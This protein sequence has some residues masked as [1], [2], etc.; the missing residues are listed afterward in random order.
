MLTL[1]C[2]C[3]FELCFIKQKKSANT[4][5]T[6]ISGH[7]STTAQ[8]LQFHTELKKMAVIAKEKYFLSPNKAK[9]GKKR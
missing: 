7:T 2:T 9:S 4:A 8:P 1:G 6:Q 3:A 5:K